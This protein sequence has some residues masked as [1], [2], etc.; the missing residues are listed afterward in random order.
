MTP[1]RY[2]VTLQLSSEN[3]RGQSPNLAEEEGKIKVHTDAAGSEVKA[4]I[5]I[6]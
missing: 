3:I 4:V 6:G 1:Q 5:F 2:N